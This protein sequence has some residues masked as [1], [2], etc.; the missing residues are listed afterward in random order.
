MDKNS[1]L[2]D[3]ARVFASEAHQRIDQ[4]RKYSGQPYTAH[5][6]AVA[7]IV[8]SVTDSQAAVAASWLHD[9]VEDTPATIEDIA[10][11]FGPEVAELVNALTDIS[12]PSDGNRKQRKA[13]DRRHLARAPSLAKTV[14][15]ADLIDN[16][17]DI[18]RHDPRFGRVFLDEMA[19]LF[20]RGH[21]FILLPVTNWAYP[22]LPGLLWARRP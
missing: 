6:K 5:L 12:R 21:F 3:R 8:A 19:L 14:K 7:D 16:C 1:D 17:A 15:L 10:S 2:I 22:L 18:C 11:T 4:R 13:A 20:R 9:V